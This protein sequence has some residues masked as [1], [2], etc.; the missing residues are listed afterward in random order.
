MHRPTTRR[1]F[2]K[3]AS[4]VSAGA[5]FAGLGMTTESYGRIV[6]ANDRLNFAV[7]GLRS[8]GQA[9]RDS[10][11]D[12]KNVHLSH[13]CDVDQRYVAKFSEKCAAAFGQAPTLIEDYR[14]LLEVQDLDA[15]AIATPDHLHA[16][17][18][19]MGVQA[20]KHV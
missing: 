2:L 1:T 19:I 11:A 15:V 20:D 7:V 8:R 6:G 18:A 5:A 16:P 13:V 17:M 14:K 12:C 9:H 4:S 3:Q 10:L